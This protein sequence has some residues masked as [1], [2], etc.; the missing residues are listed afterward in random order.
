MSTVRKDA[1]L[2][3]GEYLVQKGAITVEQLQGALY[4]QICRGL[5]FGEIAVERGKLNHDQLDKARKIQKGNEHPDKKIGQIAEM[6]G[7]LTN[8]DIDEVL[9]CQNNS[10]RKLGDILIEQEVVSSD[11]LNGYLSDFHALKEG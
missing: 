5:L 1:P 6:L 7:Y 8:D 4:V 11:E 10:Q 9:V 2:V 3:F